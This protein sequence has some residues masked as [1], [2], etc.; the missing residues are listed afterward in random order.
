ME[1]EDDS[2]SRQEN[3]L[4]VAYKEGMKGNG[5]EREQE[6]IE[7]TRTRRDRRQAT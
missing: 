4:I 6:R 2:S 5:N 3:W 1:F 7:L